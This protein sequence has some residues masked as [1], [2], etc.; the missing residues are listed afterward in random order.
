M[1][2]SACAT[3][4]CCARHALGAQP[5]GMQW[6]AA[7]AHPAL[8]PTAPRASQVAEREGAGGERELLVKWRRFELDPADDSWLSED[9][10]QEARAALR[11]RI[12]VWCWPGCACAGRRLPVLT[13][14]SP[15]PLQCRAWRS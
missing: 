14:A 7:P 3:A 1:W 11:Q 5:A 13:H 4:V 10:L 12:A 6:A 15:L 9:G 8:R 2:N